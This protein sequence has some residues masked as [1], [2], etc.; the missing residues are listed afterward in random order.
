MKLLFDQNI[1]FRITEILKNHFPDSKHI[2]QIGLT[3]KKDKEIWKY[4]KENDYV[5]VTFDSDF[6]DF[7]TLYGSPPKVIWLRIGNTSTDRI[8]EI[9]IDKF[10][11]IKNFTESDLQKEISVLEIY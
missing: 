6:Q 10:D 9:L 11:T 3:N 4:A 1:S 8:A 7:S 5:I 2:N